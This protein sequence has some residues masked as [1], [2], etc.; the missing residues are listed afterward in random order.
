[1][2]K[3]QNVKTVR[4]HPKVTSKE[5]NVKTVRNHPKVTSVLLNE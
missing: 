5:Q 2:K 4:N 3:E 1:M